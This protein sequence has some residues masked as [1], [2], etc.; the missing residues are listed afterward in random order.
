MTRT[1]WRNQ[2]TY[3]QPALYTQPSPYA[4]INF[5]PNPNIGD[6]FIAP[7]GSTYE[8]DGEVWI[9][10]VPNI[11]GAANVPIDANPP[12][13]AVSGQLWWRNDPDG[14]L[15]I[16]YNDGTSTQWVPAMQPGGGAPGI[17]DAPADG[18]MYV[19]QDGAWVAVTIPPG[20]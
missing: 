18:Q 12:A 3:R 6:Q 13:G 10:I 8:W 16:L 14:N 9:G 4:V 7:N 17:E 11:S 1:D 5:P 19:R 15:Y 2:K 20:P